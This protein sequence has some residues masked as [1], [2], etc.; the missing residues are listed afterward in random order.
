MDSG[1]A[2]LSH[3]GNDEHKKHS[4]CAHRRFRPHFPKTKRT[5][6]GLVVP[7][8][9]NLDTDVPPHRRRSW[10]QSYC[11]GWRAGA[12]ASC[13]TALVV[14][15][16]NIIVMIWAARRYPVVNSVGVIFTGECARAKR[17]NTWLQFI[18]NAFSSILLAASNFCMQCLVSPTREEVDRAHSKG[19]TLDI[20]IPSIRNLKAVRTERRVLWAGLAISAL[21]LHFVSVSKNI[22]LSRVTLTLRSGT[23]PSFFLRLKRILTQ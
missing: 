5:G 23:T 19:K 2:Q 9:K 15:I 12:T 14:L 1:A 7:F 13:V 17:L 10:R 6:A 16:I 18:V 20:G 4:T 3:A 11:E 22:L 8:V 21:P